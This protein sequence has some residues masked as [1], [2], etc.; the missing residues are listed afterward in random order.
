MNNFS[1][2]LNIII[3][4]FGMIFYL[5]VEYGGS[6][7]K[8]VTIDR[9]DAEVTLDSKGDM[10]VIERWEMDYH[11]N[12]RV[13][14][15]DIKYVK[16]APDYPLVY[17][18]DNRAQFV[19]SSVDVK[20]YRNGVNQTSFIRVG[21][22]SRGE[23]D[24]LGDLIQ[25]PDRTSECE[26]IFVDT[27][28]A[29]RLDGKVTFVYTYTIQGVITKYS[30]ISEF[31]W[32]LFEYAEGT[33]KDASITF[34]LP[35]N[36][37]DTTRFYVWGHGL[38][39]G[40]IEI[41]D[42]RTIEVTMKNIKNGEFP[43][44]RIL[45]PNSIFPNIRDM[46]IVIHPDMNFERLYN[47]EHDLAEASN[48]RIF[49]ASVIFYGSLGLI[50]WMGYVT[51]RVYLKHDKE[52]EPEFQGDYYR[53][54]PNEATPAEVSYLYYMKSIHDEVFTATLLDLIRR[55]YI[56]IIDD[57]TATSDSQSNIEFKRTKPENEHVLLAHE[58]VLMNMIFDMIGNR[59]ETSTKRI[60]QFTSIYSNAKA[61]EN[62]TNEF[63]REAKKVSEK[64][65]Y[66]ESLHHE[67]S[68]IRKL[69]WIPFGYFGL[70][71]IL[72]MFLSIDTFYAMGISILI[73]ITYLIYIHRFQ[74]RSKSGNELYAKWKAFRNFLMNF[75]NMEDYPIPAIIVW[76]H[77]LIYATVF[78]LADQVMEQLKV[79]LPKEVF[80]Q[81]ESTYLG[82]GYRRYGYSHYY[83][84]RSMTNA[85]QG[86][87]T[88]A[89]QSIARH[90]QA[91]ASSGGRGGGFGGGSSFGGGGGGGR[92]R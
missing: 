16:Y 11:D 33:I 66:F 21:L 52:Y 91:Q 20:F 90:N 28:A 42:N 83:L 55:G 64:Q 53:E 65:H 74:R 38:S 79:K 29:G 26:S 39:Q 70:S 71:V 23:Y 51:Y 69:A 13:R 67:K 3:V 18:D 35:N 50:V 17:D 43:E 92:S 41:L 78:K 63:V 61:F 57:I 24:E 58:K 27:H 37:F 44:F 4:I 72:W 86:A 49:I 48:R 68:T 85:Y 25:C 31:N 2:H 81:S 45:M 10:T 5:I 60:E 82:Y 59:T 19:S 46:N 7:G 36:S 76:E 30:D 1:R 89:A 84:H 15:R 77:Y 75:S 80:E 62:K 87:K 9:Y 40:N 22:A 73:G 8:S 47:Y 54:L 6:I 32:R 56:K 88:N 14:F 12:M 34:N